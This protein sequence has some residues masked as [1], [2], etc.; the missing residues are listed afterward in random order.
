MTYR[1]SGRVKLL[2]L[3][4]LPEVS[5]SEARRRRDAARILLRDGTDPLAAKTERK[6]TDRRTTDAS[7]SKAAAAWLACKR[8]GWAEAT[9][10]KA[11]RRSPA[12]S[13]GRV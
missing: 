3:G 11:E 4:V 2:A 5:L 6:A 10:R 12:F 9:Y 8:K 13:S 7:L 1:F